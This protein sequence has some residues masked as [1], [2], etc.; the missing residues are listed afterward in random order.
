MSVP[1]TDIPLALSNRPVKVGHLN[2]TV[3]ITC[4]D[5]EPTTWGAESQTTVRDTCENCPNW[6][7]IRWGIQ[8]GWLTTDHETNPS[9]FR[10][11]RSKPQRQTVAG[12]PRKEQRGHQVHRPHGHFVRLDGKW[13]ST[14]TMKA[15]SRRLRRVGQGD[16]QWASPPTNSPPRTTANTRAPSPALSPTDRAD[17]ATHCQ[18]LVLGT[19]GA[20]RLR[21]KAHTFKPQKPGRSAAC[22]DVISKITV[23]STPINRLPLNPCAAPF[24]PGGIDGAAGAMVAKALPSAS[25]YKEARR[26][27]ERSQLS[28]LPVRAAGGISLSA[29]VHLPGALP[30]VIPPKITHYT[31]TS[32]RPEEQ[33]CPACLQDAGHVGSSASLFLPGQIQ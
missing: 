5:E 16:G 21:V 29:R 10:K 1:N 18:Q 13:V 22:D 6:E 27:P 25:P 26:Q 4:D 20:G 15:G 9:K 2:N 19:N 33:H 3:K 31:L 12:P 11:A 23:D 24:Y 30:Q 28:S 14:K 32:A 8:R 7:P 17:V